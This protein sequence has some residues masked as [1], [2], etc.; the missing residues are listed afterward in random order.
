MLTTLLAA[1]P[2]AISFLVF[3]QSIK[4]DNIGLLSELSKEI[5][6]E[7]PC[8]YVVESLISKIHRMRPIPFTDALLILK[9]DNSFEIM[10]NLSRCRGILELIKPVINGDV[11]GFEYTW[12]FAT[13]PRRIGCMALC[14]AVVVACFFGTLHYTEVLVHNYQVAKAFQK[15]EHQLMINELFIMAI[16][17]IKFF[18]VFVLYMTFSIQFIKIVFSHIRMMK[19]NELL[20]E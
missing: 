11:L 10:L 3:I 19:I 4:K 2:I 6:S 14:M 12:L 15:N 16:N 13:W 8:P 18:F 7:H 20:E 9:K 5:S 17:A 1:L